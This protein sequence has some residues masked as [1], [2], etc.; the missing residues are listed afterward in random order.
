MAGIKPIEDYSKRSMKTKESIATSRVLSAG[1]YSS[2]MRSA[3]RN[4]N[5]SSKKD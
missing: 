1:K 3:S 4:N 2:T 5:K